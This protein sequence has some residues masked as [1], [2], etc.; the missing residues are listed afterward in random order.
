[1]VLPDTQP[2]PLPACAPEGTP[3][4]PGDP[5]APFVDDPTGQPYDGQ[6]YDGQPYDDGVHDDTLHDEVVLRNVVYDHVVH[7]DGYV[8]G[9]A[10]AGPRDVEPPPGPPSPPPQSP[11]G[12]GPGPEPPVLDSHWA[13]DSQ[14]TRLLCATAHLHGEYA[15]TV[16]GALLD[17]SFTAIAPSWGLDPVALAQHAK[18]SQDRRRERDRSLRFCLA[19]MVLIPLAVVA[20]GLVGGLPPFSVAL[21][22]VVVTVAGF[23]VAWMIVFAHYELIRIS[24]LEAMDARFNPRET[25]PALPS[26]T[27]QRLKDLAEANTVV[28]GGYQ[29]FVGCGVTLDSWTICVDLA[30]DLSGG[31]VPFNPLDLHDHLLRTIPPQTPGGLWAA[32]RLFIAGNAAKAVPGLVPEPYEPDTWPANRLPDEVLRAYTRK[33]T[34]TARTYVCLAHPAWKGEIVVSMLVRAELAGSK[35]FIEG[36]THALLPPRA[37]FREYKYV[38]KHP[39]RAWIAVARASTG[40]LA[41]L[42]FGCYTR[43]FELMKGTR[44]FLRNRQRM[45]RQ[46]AQGHPFNYG[47]TGSLREDVADP[48]ELKYYAA[49]DEVRA[50]RML[51]RQ[52]LGEIDTFLADHGVDVADFRRQAEESL[53][54][55]A[56][57]LH[58][59][60]ASGDSFGPKNT[61]TVRDMNPAPH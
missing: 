44:R 40:V 23:V 2:L 32:P 26:A 58:D 20:L 30:P 37:T 39:R 31:V 43:K 35:L 55:T 8:D 21:S 1:M 33:P 51:K 49:V 61:V 34:E 29:P 27:R 6:P 13:Q 60:A 10:Q 57:H 11:T 16:I 48:N 47:A 5:A 52:I 19:G 42:L 38:P 9:A 53:A 54:E 3:A 12:L 25:A 28:F 4:A 45:R 56:V 22:V 46:L 7:D 15:E 24:V 18:L 14:V 50:F 59:L 17:P 36:R 41:P